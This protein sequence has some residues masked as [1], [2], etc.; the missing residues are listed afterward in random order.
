MAGDTVSKRDFY[1][2]L[3][4]DRGA[5]DEA[6]KKA[7]RRLAMKFHPDRAGDD[8]ESETQFKEAKEAFEVLSDSDKRAAYD[9]FGHQ[10]VDA[11]GGGAG[12]GQ[13][14]PGFGAGDIFGDIFGEIFGRGRRGGGGGGPRVY[15]GA[16]LR[17]DLTISLERAVAGHSFEIRV[18]RTENCDTCDGSGASKGSTP[19]DCSTCGGI[20]EVRVQQGMFTMQQTCP[21]CR[22][23]GK[24]ISDP[25]G[26]CLG[27][28]QVRRTRTLSVKV[29]PGIDTGDRIRLSGEGELG[30]N[31]GPPGDL[32]VIV[33]LEPHE[34]FERD[35][36]HLACEVPIS[37]TR[38]ALGGSVEV[39]TLQGKARIDVPGGT[40]TGKVFRLRGKGVAPVRGGATGDLYCKVMIETPV[41]LTA[42][43][44]ELLEQLD[45]TLTEGGETHSPK[46]HSWLD[47]VKSFFSSLGSE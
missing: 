45:E 15:R 42:A 43:Q 39:P 26:S 41:N 29:P 18:P 12:G 7:Y 33:E 31:G 32:Y 13:G 38:A 3:G 25:C 9:R 11:M 46:A 20:G 21:N 35:G 24:T 28:G 2:V 27:S 5:D 1:E 17:Y 8:S 30:Q 36:S 23:R 4:V 22:G 14:G 16:D 44:R 10:G 6:L 37:L 47:G 34:I 19:E 40:Q